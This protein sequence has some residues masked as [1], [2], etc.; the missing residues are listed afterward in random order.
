LED[1]NPDPRGIMRVSYG[2]MGLS[3]SAERHIFDR[4]A[5]RKA[6]APY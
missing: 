4:Y 2:I 3:T 6:G 5:R 1:S